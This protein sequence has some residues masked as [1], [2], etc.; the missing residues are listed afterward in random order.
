VCVDGVAA[1]H[2][3]A[4]ALTEFDFFIVKILGGGE[5]IDQ[6]PVALGSKQSAREKHGVE[7]YVVFAHELLVLD[8]LG[9]TRL[10][11]LPPAVSLV[12]GDADVADGRVKPH[13]EDLA[14]LVLER[15]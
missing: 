12:G 4:V 15:D 9:V 7:L 3:C 2:A 13:L 5:C 11:P 6:L 10:P 14:G 1:E 8:L